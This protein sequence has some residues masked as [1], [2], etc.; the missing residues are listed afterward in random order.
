LGIQHGSGIAHDER[1]HEHERDPHPH[2]EAQPL[3]RQ[4]QPS[5]EVRPASPLT[6]RWVNPRV[7]T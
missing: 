2:D 6:I 3:G 7:L 1:P 4:P 5:A